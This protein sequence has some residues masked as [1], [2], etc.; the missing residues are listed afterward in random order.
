MKICKKPT[1]VRVGENRTGLENRIEIGSL[2]LIISR[3]EVD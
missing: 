1:R 2:H 3:G